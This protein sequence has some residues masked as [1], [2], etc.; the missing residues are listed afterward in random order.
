MA[1]ASQ[2]TRRIELGTAVTP[3]GWENPLRLA[4][5]LA[6]VDVLSG[7]RL[8][9][10]CQRRPADAVRPTSRTRSTPTP[11]TRRTS[12]TAGSSGCSRSCAASRPAAFAGTQGIEVFSERVEPHTPGLA[13]RVWYGAASLGS[14][15]WAGEHG[16][17]L[18]T[19]SVVKAE[20]PRPDF[21]AMQR[22]QIAAFRAAHPAGRRG[23]GCRRA[24]S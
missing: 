8:N 7:G 16:L 13:D 4:E 17:N 11:P 6:T 10:G 21:A 12:A 18:L 24:W 1:A 19:S 23:P 5:D 2:R 15:R 20:E 9:P 14:A 3:L 22:S